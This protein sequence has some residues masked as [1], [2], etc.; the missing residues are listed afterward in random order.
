MVATASGLVEF[1]AAKCFT[2]LFYFQQKVNLFI[3]FMHIST[4]PACM[5]VFN[6]HV[7]SLWRQKRALGLLELEFQMAVRYH[8]H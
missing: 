2:F 6:M 3:L 7:W 1:F 8:E 4:F 5:S